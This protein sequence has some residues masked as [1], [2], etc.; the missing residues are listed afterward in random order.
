MAAINDQNDSLAGKKG[1][2]LWAVSPEDGEKLA[3]LPLD[4]P[5]IF[6]GMIVAGG[7]LYMTTMDGKL[8]CYAGQ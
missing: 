3:E 7:R 2:V 6:D 5:P 4:S 8:V 1:G